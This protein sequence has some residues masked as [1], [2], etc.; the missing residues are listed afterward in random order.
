MTMTRTKTFKEQMMAANSGLTIYSYQNEEDFWFNNSDQSNYVPG[1]P[2]PPS[3]NRCCRNQQIEMS[4]I[5]YDLQVQH[6]KEISELLKRWKCAEAR[7]QQ[8]VA[9]AESEF[10]NLEAELNAKRDELRRM[11]NSITEEKLQR[12]ICVQQTQALQRRLH[13]LLK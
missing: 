10:S 9:I 7:N 8:I 4:A 1:S 11:H 2:P 3:N 12:R 13:H 6:K 5:Q